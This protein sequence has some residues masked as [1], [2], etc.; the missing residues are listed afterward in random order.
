MVHRGVNWEEHPEI[1]QAP[2]HSPV[3][4]NR[5]TRTKAAGIQLLG[6][7]LNTGGQQ[8]E[9]RHAPR[10]QSGPALCGQHEQDTAMRA[11]A[12]I[13]PLLC[14]SPT[15]LECCSECRKDTSKT[16]KD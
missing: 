3:P 8:A 15:H 11:Q 12:S 1:Q 14:G 6:R 10:Q 4:G 5:Q 9:V 7:A 2:T 13:T 16:G